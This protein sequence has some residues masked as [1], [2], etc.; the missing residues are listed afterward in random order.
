RP[1]RRLAVAAL[2]PLPWP[3]VADPDLATLR[4]PAP[5]L[6][7]RLAELQLRPRQ[8]R[9][10]LQPP[11]LRF[12]QMQ[13]VGG[14]KE[15]PR[16]LPPAG[17]VQR[18]VLRVEPPRQQRRDVLAHRA[19]IRR[20]QRQRP[21]ECAVRLRIPAGLVHAE[22]EEEMRARVVRRHLD[23][24]LR[25]SRVLL[26][27]VRVRQVPEQVHRRFH[28]P[29]IRLQRRAEVADHTLSLLRLQVCERYYVLR[30]LRPLPRTRDRQLVVRWRRWK[31]APRTLRE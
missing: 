7:S 26:P 28:V 22:A 12:R 30:L 1:R 8:P 18:R 14:R 15:D 20:Q 11:L 3:A 9:V 27:F 5:Q 13:R 19:V 24:Q 31:L 10:V 29:R 2:V 6:P 16:R 21:S 17:A 25:D 23:E 4:L